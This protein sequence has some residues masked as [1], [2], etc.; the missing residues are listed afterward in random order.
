MMV[1]GLPFT[2]FII[3]IVTA[4]AALLGFWWQPYSS[5][6]KNFW[7]GFFLCCFYLSGVFALIALIFAVFRIE[8]QW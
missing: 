5:W 8:M 3:F 4:A 6:R 7:Q 2:L 1:N